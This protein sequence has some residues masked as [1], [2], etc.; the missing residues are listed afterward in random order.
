MGRTFALAD[1][2]LSLRGDKPMDVFGALWKD[3]PERMAD[4]WDR[5]VEPDDDVL[6]PGDLSWGRTLEEAEPDLAWIGARPGRKFLLRGNHDGWWASLSKVRRAL[7]EGCEPLQNAAF[8][9][10]GRVLVGARGWTAP[11]DPI[12]T[13]RDAPL[14]RRELERLRHSIA[15][16]DARLPR[17]KPRIAMLHFPPWIVGREPTEVVEI[18]ERGEV[19]TVVYGHLHGEDHAL[20]VTGRHRGI[21]FHLVAAD[22]V[23]F[24]PV[25]IP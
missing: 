17:H 2:H 14:F 7:P 13:E 10:G 25:E 4:A 1:L 20:G 8:D 9:L 15:D 23:G 16:A 11:D 22:A 5:L 12:A 19:A 24:R 21:D 18:L 6:L 3:H